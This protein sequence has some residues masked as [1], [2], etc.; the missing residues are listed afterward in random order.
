MENKKKKKKHYNS[1]IKNLNGIKSG[2]LVLL[3]YA[4][5]KKKQVFMRKC[6]RFT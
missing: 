5:G 2:E 1:L 3:Q 6:P 4:H